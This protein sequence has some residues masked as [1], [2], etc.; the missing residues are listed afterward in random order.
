[1]PIGLTIWFY[2][3]RAECFQGMNSE[4][5]Q[6]WFYCC[7]CSKNNLEIINNRTETC[8]LL[9]WGITCCSV[10][11]ELNFQKPQSASSTIRNVGNFYVTTC[12]EPQF[13]YPW[14]K[15]LFL[16]PIYLIGQGKSFA[17]LRIWLKWSRKKKSTSKILKFFMKFELIHQLLNNYY[18]KIIS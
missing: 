10:I 5:H 6:I 17:M 15:F 12:A 9:W 14:C 4:E 1:M 13:S 16:S 2:L 11:A 3:L 7:C 8:C 18:M